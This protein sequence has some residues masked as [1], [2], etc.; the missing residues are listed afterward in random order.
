MGKGSVDHSALATATEKKKH[1][2]EKKKMEQVAVIGEEAV[3][4][5]EPETEGVQEEET[6]G[7]KGEDVPEEDESKDVIKEEAE[8]KESD[9]DGEK[10]IEG[11][12]E[13]E[14]QPLPELQSIKVKVNRFDSVDVVDAKTK[15]TSVDEADAK[16]TNSSSVDETDAKKIKE[17]FSKHQEEPHHQHG[18]EVNI[19]I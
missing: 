5:A 6:E 4:S 7:N 18:K 19:C 16:V 12:K 17:F 9:L 14:V 15:S 13:D 8:E 1:C 10:D 11:S 2:L 3:L